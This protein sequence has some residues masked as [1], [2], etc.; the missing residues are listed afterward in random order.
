MSRERVAA[1][2]TPPTCGEV[3][4]TRLI[5]AGVGRSPEGAGV[6]VERLRE[7]AEASRGPARGRTGGTLTSPVAAGPAGSGM[8]PATVIGLQRAAG[9]A[10]VAGLLGPGTATGGHGGLPTIQRDKKKKAPAK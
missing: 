1:V 10:A 8:R 9:N 6:G 4:R 5:A 3:D 2:P 7:E